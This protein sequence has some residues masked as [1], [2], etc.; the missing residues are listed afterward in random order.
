MRPYVVRFVSQRSGAGKTRVA[1]RVVEALVKAGYDVGVIKHA[2]S[3]ISLEEKDSARYLRAGATE[4]LVASSELVLLYSRAVTDDLS[5]L[6]KR[7]GKPLVVVEGFRGSRLG[8]S[9]VVAENADDATRA[10]SESAI[11][12][13]YSG[14]GTD[15]DRLDAG[16]VPVIPIDGVDALLDLIVKRAVEHF[17]AQLPG[18]D[19]G[20]CGSDSCRAMSMKILKGEKRICPVV[21]DVKVTVNDQEVPLNP[22]VKSVVRSVVEGLLASLKWVPHRMNRITIEID[23]RGSSK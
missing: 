7:V 19:C 6:V 12:V 3:G 18:L 22:F 16:S 4:V 8:D 10:L 11:A 9:V 5:E 14:G 21:T 17:V 20:A 13:V 15:L 1:S 23:G 2:A